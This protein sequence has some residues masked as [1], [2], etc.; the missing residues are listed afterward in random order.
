MIEEYNNE[1]YE[2]GENEIEKFEL[3][4]EENELTKNIAKDLNKKISSIN[5]FSEFEDIMP[6]FLTEELNKQGKIMNE[7]TAMLN[8]EDIE[9][10]EVEEI[11]EKQNASMKEFTSKMN[12]AGFMS[13]HEGAIIRLETEIKCFSFDYNIETD[14]LDIPNKVDFSEF[15]IP[16]EIKPYIEKGEYQSVYAFNIPADLKPYFEEYIRMTEESGDFKLKENGYIV[17][18]T[19]SYEDEPN[20][21]YVADIIEPESREITDRFTEE[22]KEKLEDNPYIDY[23][24]IAFR[25]ED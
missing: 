23:D 19:Y 10:E 7:L 20:K 17:K 9:A 21:I 8:K 14:F 6:E 22:E 13:G 5:K 24:F 18:L 25:E 16:E 4:N 12:E 3:L 11:L 2:E 15:D 1:E